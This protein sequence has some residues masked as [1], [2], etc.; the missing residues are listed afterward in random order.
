MDARRRADGPRRRRRRDAAASR[1]GRPTARGSPSADGVGDQSGLIVVA[2]RRIGARVPRADDQAPT[3]RAHSTRQRHRLVA[4]RSKRIAFVTPRRGPRRRIADGDPIVITR[5]LYK[6]DGVGRQHALQRQP[7]PPHLLV[8]VAHGKP[9]TQLTD[10]IYYEH[11]IDWS[12]D[13]DE[14][15]L[16]LQPRAGARPVLQLRSLRAERGRRNACGA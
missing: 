12:P 7:P 6:P 8:D 4:R 3:A 16:R 10:G 1:S 15:L 11:S 13:G 2:R 5:Y 14:I 9:I